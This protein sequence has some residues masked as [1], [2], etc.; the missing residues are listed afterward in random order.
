MV[1]DGARSRHSRRPTPGLRISLASLLAATL[2][3]GCGSTTAHAPSSRELA[4]ER[5]QFAQVAGELRTLEGAVQNEVA[6][7]R[8]VWPLIANGLPAA[9]PTTLHSAV[10]RASARA[11]AIRE[12][13]FMANAH[14]LTGPASGIAGLYENYERLTERGWRLTAAGIT[15]ITHASPTVAGFARQSSALYIDAIYDAHFDLSLL[16]KSVASGYGKL[17]GASAFGA[18]LTPAQVSA[19]DAAY[20]IP[21]VRLEPHPARTVAEG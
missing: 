3:A 17:G 2:I 14:K 11:S 13:R 18:S 5:A 16:G 7:S 10:E 15:A 9:L 19:L 8:R 20:S 1:K 6:A 4:L 21:S 12:P